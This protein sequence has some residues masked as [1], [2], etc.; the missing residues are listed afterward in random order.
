LEK[1]GI[2][3]FEKIAR[4]VAFKLFS[5]PKEKRELNLS[6]DESEFLM[7][8]IDSGV[9]G[10]MKNGIRSKLSALSENGKITFGVKAKYVLRRLFPKV[11]FYLFC[12]PVVYKHKILI[13]GYLFIR[14]FK[15][16]FTRPKSLITEL[17]ALKTIK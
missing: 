1:L 13:P 5:E 7:Y 2:A 15:Y 8:Y 14:F 6:S 11:D 3:D 9:Y 10:N 12:C 4:S 17:K 16:I